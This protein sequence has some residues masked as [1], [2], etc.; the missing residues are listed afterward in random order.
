MLLA[1][2]GVV[3]GTRD[4][5]PL[6]WKRFVALLLDGCRAE[7]AHP[8]PPPPPPAQV[9]RAMRRL[10]RPDARERTGHLGKRPRE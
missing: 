3:R 1:N 6:A 10:A 9:Y 5:A 8:L 4:A 7:G 2:A